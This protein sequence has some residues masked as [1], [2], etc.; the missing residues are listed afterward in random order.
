MPGPISD[1]HDPDPETDAT[2]DVW[3]EDIRARGLRFF[4]LK[5]EY[6]LEAIND[7]DPRLVQ[8]FN[9]MLHIMGKWQAR[10]G[11]T[12]GHRYYVINKDEPWADE[13]SAVLEKHNIF[14]HRGNAT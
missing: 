4:V 7:V 2:I 10:H 14:P 1:S 3:M 5:G 8:D 12:L 6:F 9:R 13:V 11:K